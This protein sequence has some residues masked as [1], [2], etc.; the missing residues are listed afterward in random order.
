MKTVEPM[1]S[2]QALLTAV[3]GSLQHL[4]SQPHVGSRDEGMASFSDL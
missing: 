4:L 2:L 1:E 3:L